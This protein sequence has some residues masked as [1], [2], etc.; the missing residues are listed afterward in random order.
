[1]CNATTT[2]ANPP[3]N[4]TS[5]TL[6]ATAVGTLSTFQLPFTQVQFYYFDNAPGGTNQ[7][8]LIGSS[9]ASSVT[10]DGVLLTRTFTWTISFDPPAAF[11]TGGAAIPILAVGMNASGD[12]LASRANSNITVTP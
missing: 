5:T 12:A 9:V 2:C 1:L 10:D 8:K 4:A 6:R 7:W 11:G 3:G